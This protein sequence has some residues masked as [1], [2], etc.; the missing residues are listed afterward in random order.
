MKTR[1]TMSRK[2]ASNELF[3]CDWH[4]NKR[5]KWQLVIG[6]LRRM[7]RNDPRAKRQLSCRKRHKLQV[8]VNCVL[9]VY[10]TC[11]ADF[12]T[13]LPSLRL[14]RKISNYFC[15]VYRGRVVTFFRVQRYE[16]SLTSDLWKRTF[17]AMIQMCFNVSKSTKFR[18]T[19][20]LIL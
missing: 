16:F 8:S 14:T 2:I 15:D 4:T 3:W 9:C 20:K 10:N 17:L 12:I 13:S 11:T 5:R 19:T 7:L 18:G 6:W 1:G